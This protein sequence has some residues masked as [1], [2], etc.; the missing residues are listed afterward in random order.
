M[1][2]QATKYGEAKR[3]TASYARAHFKALQQ[4]PPSQA[5]ETDLALF[6]TAKEHSLSVLKEGILNIISS[7]DKPSSPASEALSDFSSNN[8]GFTQE[9]RKRFRENV[10][11]TTIDKLVSVSE[12][13]LTVKPCR[14]ILTSKKYKNTIDKLNFKTKYI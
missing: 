4:T 11:S 14:S 6:S 10:L 13:Y 7:I 1:K 9:M 8:S 2:P 5:L 3:S 12:K